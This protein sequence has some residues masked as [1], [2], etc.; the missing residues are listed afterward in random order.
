MIS[1]VTAFQNHKLIIVAIKYTALTAMM[2]ASILLS[3]Q[4]FFT[5]Y[6]ST[7]QESSSQCIGST[8]L[9][10]GYVYMGGTGRRFI[11]PFAL[12]V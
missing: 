6:Y 1:S 7:Q 12:T 9:D 3:L 4:R 10:S 5:S 11:K 2:I 8:T